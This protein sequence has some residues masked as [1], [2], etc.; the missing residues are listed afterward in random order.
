LNFKFK[1]FSFIQTKPIDTCKETQIPCIQVCPTKFTV[2][3]TKS[4]QNFGEFLGFSQ[5]V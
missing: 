2:V 1:L 3:K 4:K 5:K